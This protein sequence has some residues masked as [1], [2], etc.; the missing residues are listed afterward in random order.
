MTLSIRP[1]RPTFA[2]EVLEKISIEEVR[3]GLE[4]VLFEKLNESEEL[5]R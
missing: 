5:P 4:K 1:I 3:K 2:A